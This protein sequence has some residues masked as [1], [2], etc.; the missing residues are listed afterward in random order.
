MPSASARSPSAWI[1][2]G[3]TASSTGPYAT[4]SSSSPG[5]RRRQALR[6]SSSRAAPAARLSG[7]A[8][9]SA[10]RRTAARYWAARSRVHPPRTACRARA[11]AWPPRASARSGNGRCTTSSSAPRVASSERVAASSV[12]RRSYDTALRYASGQRSPGRGLRCRCPPST[13]GTATRRTSTP[14]GADAAGPCPISTTWYPAARTALATRSARESPS[15]GP[16]ATT[17]TR[18]GARK[19][20]AIPV[21]DPME[22][23]SWLREPSR[24]ANASPEDPARPPRRRTPS[25]PHTAHIR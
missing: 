3:R 12:V 8:S 19:A 18:R 10:R 22:M 9:G 24:R 1:R 4:S 5:S 21:S 7:H 11:S 25:P 16:T 17:A 14:S 23:I 6:P 2:C 15:S 13:D 20:S